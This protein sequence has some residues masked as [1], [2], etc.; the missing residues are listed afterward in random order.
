MPLK[1]KSI[2]IEEILLERIKEAI[3]RNDKTE[4]GRLSQKAMDPE[5]MDNRTI[6]LAGYQFDVT[7]TI[8]SGSNAYEIL[9]GWKL[10]VNESIPIDIY[11]KAFFFF[12]LD[13][14]LKHVIENDT[15]VDEETYIS[16]ILEPLVLELLRLCYWIHKCKGTLDQKSFAAKFAEVKDNLIFR[17]VKEYREDLNRKFRNFGK[18]MANRSIPRWERE[19]YE[20]E[21]IIELEF[22]QFRSNISSFVPEFMSAAL[23]KEAGFDIDFIATAEEKRCDLLLNSFKIEVKTFLDRSNEAIKVEKSLSEEIL[24]TLKR[25]KA[26]RDIRDA[27]CKK[28]D[29]VLV[30]LSFTSLGIGFPKHTF[31]KDVSFALSSA[32]S[33][34][35][36]IAQHNRTTQNVEEV[37]VIIFT[38]ETDFTDCVYKMFFYTV[39]FP[40]R[41]KNNDELEP[42]PE[43]LTIDLNI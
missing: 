15:K 7:G 27:L 3:D 32:L 20:K 2:C 8:Y 41:K 33:D 17:D 36:S 26:I 24:E 1:D 6:R 10:L 9:K 28:P 42:V 34:S 38:T 29:I 14:S 5:V 11:L 18:L 31:K 22:R 30:F 43:G 35:I 21:L 4:I 16:I 12:S 37:P 19:L 13:S 40:V 39:P 23:M 25:E